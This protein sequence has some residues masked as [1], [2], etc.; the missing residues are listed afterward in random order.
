MTTTREQRPAQVATA[1]R[2]LERRRYAAMSAADIAELDGLLAEQLTYTHSNASRDT[3]AE[4]LAQ[5]TDGTF[6]YGPIAH[7]E[8]DVVV[9]D[10]VVLVIGEMTADAVIHGAPRSIRNAGLSVWVRGGAEGW[11][12][13][14]YQPT[15]I[16]R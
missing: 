4:Y 8:H 3:K 7:V 9:R 12:L 11:E 5:V 1:I 6:D 13:A 15:P 16:P 10:H 2:E 14:A